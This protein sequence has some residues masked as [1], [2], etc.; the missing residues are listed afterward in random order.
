MT[1]DADSDIAILI[2]D[3]PVTF[4]RFIQPI[5]LPLASINVFDVEGLV[6]GYGR[7]E[8]LTEAQSTLF[9]AMIHSV[10]NKICKESHRN[11]DGIV[12]TNSFCAKSNF[13]VPCHGKFLTNFNFLFNFS[14]FLR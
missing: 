6:A 13:S 10:D 5:C 2:M 3:E 9:H 12:A 1:A 14:I 11:A 8:T 7:N 4:T